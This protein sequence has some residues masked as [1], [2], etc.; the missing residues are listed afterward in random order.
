MRRLTALTAIAVS[1]LGLVGATAPA[2]AM[3]SGNPYQDIQ[4]GVDYTVYQPT[5][6][7]GAKR[8]GII[9]TDWCTAS[10]NATEN[11]N[12]RYAKGKREIYSIAEGNP[13][14][15]DFAIGP[16]VGTATVS[17]Q[18]AEIFAY[19]PP[20]GNG[21]SRNDIQRYGG[22][23]TATLP[24]AKGLKPT[25]LVIETK[26]KGLT[27]AQLVIVAASLKPLQ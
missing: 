15:F 26:P 9:G 6:V 20:P 2:L 5:N 1:V 16:K 10:S 18:P 13:L 12:A 22:K 17:G 8:I 21:C 14:C 7:L 4:V 25:K 19:C 27:A 23:L 24:A 3:G 11:L